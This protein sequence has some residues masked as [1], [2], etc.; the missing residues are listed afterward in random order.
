MS[1][2]GFPQPRFVASAAAADQGV[3]R[4]KHI[5]PL[6]RL[7]HRRSPPLPSLPSWFH[8]AQYRLPSFI[9]WSLVLEKVFGQIRRQVIF[10]SGRNGTTCNAPVKSEEKT[11]AESCLGIPK[12]LYIS[13][14][15]GQ[16]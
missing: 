11:A 13:I 10:S 2:C 12:S 14:H 6:F 1:R 8:N 4:Q 9:T 15:I 16:D 3:L 7:H 5:P